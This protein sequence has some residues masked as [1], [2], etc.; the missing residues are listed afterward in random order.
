M[1]ACLHAPDFSVQAAVRLEDELRQQP[2]AIVD[3]SPPLQKVVALNLQAREKGM[4]LGMTNA[5]AELFGAKL[6]RRNRTQEAEARQ[7]LLDCAFAF[8]PRV[9]DAAENDGSV[10]LDIDGLE[11]LH[12]DAQSIGQALQ[13]LGSELGFELNA[14]I[15]TNPEAAALAARGFS[16]ITIIPA[17]FELECLGPLPISILG[18]SLELQETFCSWGIH[19]LQ[20]LAAL[21]E[22]G[23]IARLGQEGKR[24]QTLARGASQR[25]LIPME[26]E[27]KFEE[28]LELEFPIELL[29]P[30]TFTLARL[31]QP[32]CARLAAR[33]LAA[34]AIALTLEL[35]PQRSAV[36]LDRSGQKRK[37]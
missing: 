33:G 27:L 12:G 8:S 34:G 25:P 35:E 9:E 29:E 4:R 16:G 31:L 24:L 30:L 28:S 1:F 18:L 7:A 6:C 2:V 13:Q 17:G 22:V 23:L 15:A 32:L 36:Q 26:P 20:A 19:T 10:I 14:G 21:P 11:R 3:G 5:E 37:E